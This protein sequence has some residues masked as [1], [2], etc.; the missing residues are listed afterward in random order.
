MKR[1]TRAPPGTDF[2][3]GGRAAIPSPALVVSS[4]IDAALADRT[5]IIGRSDAG[6]R[7]HVFFVLRGSALFSAA[8]R[9]E[10]ELVA[11]TLLWL[12]PGA[13]A[14]FRLLAGGEG[15]T[16][17]ASEALTWRTIGESSIGPQLRPLLT[18]ILVAP[19]DRIAGDLEALRVSFDTML[20]ESREGRPGFSAMIGAH[21]ALV[22]LHLWRASG[23]ADQAREPGVA[24]VQ[25]FRQIVE[26]HY[27]E[28][29]SIA[30]YVR[31]L[32]VTRSHLHGAC[33]RAVGRTPL[34]L[35]HER[36][37]AEAC[38]RLEQTALSAEQIGY[39]LGFRDA[40]YFSRFFKRSTG[41]TS[42]A[43]RRHV[44]KRQ[45][46]PKPFSYAAWP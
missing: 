31:M 7:C 19:P 37:A 14:R 26:L 40:G 3:T 33:L 38:L 5:W 15:A 29:L 22:L 46:E 28:H 25:R 30:D 17:S 39:S 11:P 4:R 32:G 35:V 23:G 16:F 12:P 20:R 43:W 41:Q 13:V 27:R 36:L 8:D 42:S 18:Q 6:A 44:S 9:R 2:K 21:L 1:Q 10:S 24:T 45:I 34:D